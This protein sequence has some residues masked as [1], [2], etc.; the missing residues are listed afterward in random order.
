M[1]PPCG[2]P[3]RGGPACR[4]LGWGIC[5]NP[6]RPRS[7]LLHLLYPSDQRVN[8]PPAA[9]GLKHIPTPADL[10]DSMDKNPSVDRPLCR[11]RRS[12]LRGRFGVGNI[13]DPYRRD[14]G[15][16]RSG[17]P[18]PNRHLSPNHPAKTPACSAVIC[19][20]SHIHRIVSARVSSTG[21][22]ASPSSCSAQ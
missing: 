15:P 1:Q 2:S 6:N 4:R 14:A 7:G 18:Q 19:P 8:S 10:P 3:L 5:M 12:P 22:S 9:E 11:I 21:R 16:P 17:F 20:S 13:P